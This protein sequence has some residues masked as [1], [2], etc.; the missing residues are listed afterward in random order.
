M[1]V[2]TVAVDEENVYDE[3]YKGNLSNDLEIM[4]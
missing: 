1:H 3:A 4:L 2:P